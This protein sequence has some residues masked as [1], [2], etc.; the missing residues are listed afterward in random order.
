MRIVGN[1]TIE[2]KILP[3]KNSDPERNIVTDYRSEKIDMTDSEQNGYYN[4]NSKN[5]K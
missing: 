2:S 3:H 1:K 4:K 5:N